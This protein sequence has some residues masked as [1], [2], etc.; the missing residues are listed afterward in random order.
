MPFNTFAGWIVY[1]LS[2]IVMLLFIQW[3]LDTLGVT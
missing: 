3:G 1:C 2:V